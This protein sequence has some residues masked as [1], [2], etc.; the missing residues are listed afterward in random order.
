MTNEEQSA[1]VV[2]LAQELVEH[3][4]QIDPHWHRAFFR[5]ALA[6]GEYGSTGS[7]IART[8]VLMIDPFMHSGFFD[9]MNSKGAKLMSLLKKERGVFLVAVRSDYSYKIV[10]DFSDLNR[11]KITKL[12][13]ATGIPEGYDLEET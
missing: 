12:H 5:F 11:W 1:I 10:F 2:A 7:Y 3:M 8:N 6:P 9:S 4:G 13:G